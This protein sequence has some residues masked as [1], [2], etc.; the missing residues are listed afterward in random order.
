MKTILTILTLLAALAGSAQ[1]EE[2][3]DTVEAQGVEL[4]LFKI[5]LGWVDGENIG[6]T[7]VPPSRRGYSRFFSETPDLRSG[8]YVRPPTGESQVLQLAERGDD[9]TVIPNDR[10]F[11][12]R[13]FRRL[14]DQI[15]VSNERRQRR[16]SRVYTS[17][18][19][20][21][22]SSSS[23]LVIGRLDPSNGRC[24]RQGDASAN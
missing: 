3:P 24:T 18:R 1:A 20:N 7:S 10:G 13:Q 12:G 23:M 19:N 2:W 6:V 16:C 5:D 9:T 14:R 21:L 15:I 17:T 22:S 4:H 11:T 8:V